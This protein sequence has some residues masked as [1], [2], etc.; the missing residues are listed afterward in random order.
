VLACAAFR[1]AISCVRY[2]LLNRAP[3]EELE[4]VA[5]V[6]NGNPE[7]IRLFDEVLQADVSPA[8]LNSV[9]ITTALRTHRN[10]VLRWAIDAKFA[11]P[12]NSTIL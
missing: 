12:S 11:D 6:E 1:G 2:L 4:M 9:I 3:V 10:D 7:I 8:V 5:A